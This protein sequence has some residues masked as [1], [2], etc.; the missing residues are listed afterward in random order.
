L[1]CTTT[2]NA[3]TPSNV[4][5]IYRYFDNLGRAFIHSWCVAICST[6]TT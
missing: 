2:K 5:V 4:K 1:Q 6:W 3:T